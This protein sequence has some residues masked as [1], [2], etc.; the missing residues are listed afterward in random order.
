MVND[1]VADFL[2]RLKSA[3]DIRRSSVSVPF[4]SFKM[5]IAEKLK[6]AGFL[7]AIE[8]KGK[9][10]RKTLDVTL[11]YLESGQPAILGV[12]RISK[13]GRRVYR[14]VNEIH[15]VRYGKGAL[16]L[17][18]PKGIKT[19]KEARKEKIGGEALFE[20]W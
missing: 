12:K 19:D 17:S 11:S 16:I 8:K 5:A 15:R 7:K 14:G 18:T 9:K 3:A 4:S 20:I 13:P 10:V 1:P 6:D 2:V